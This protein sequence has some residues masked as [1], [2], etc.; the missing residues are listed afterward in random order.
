[1]VLVLG[2]AGAAVAAAPGSTSV[3]YASSGVLPPDTP[4]PS[5]APIKISISGGIQ[6]S[7]LAEFCASAP[8]R[9]ECAP[10][11]TP[12]TLAPGQTRTE[13]ADDR[14][15][16]TGDARRPYG[17]PSSNPVQVSVSGGRILCY[18]LL[19]YCET[20]NPTWYDS[21]R[22]LYCPGATTT[23]GATPASP[24][25]AG[26]AAT[27]ASAVRTSTGVRVEI[28]GSATSVGA[29]TANGIVVI[30]ATKRGSHPV[31][32]VRRVPV[33]KVATIATPRR[34][35]GYRLEVFVDGTRILVIP[36]GGTTG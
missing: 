15:E 1:L 30:R 17:C 32:L 23:T 21:D 4:C 34:L 18:T 20:M 16:L 26:P 5:S 24:A 19:G 22:G 2:P 3:A 33:G 10:G 35:V 25:D 29:A 12:T 28:A 9:E 27:T 31:L 14:I 11:A 13:F 6:C 8:F 36:P 7:T